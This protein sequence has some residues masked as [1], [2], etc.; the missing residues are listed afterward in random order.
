MKRD[1]KGGGIITQ[2][3]Q[4]QWAEYLENVEYIVDCNDSQLLGLTPFVN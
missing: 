3:D 2:Y 4:S 1:T